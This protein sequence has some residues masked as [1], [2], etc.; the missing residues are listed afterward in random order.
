[1]K[2]TLIYDNTV[3]LSGLTPDWG[4]AC[5]VEAFGRTILFDTGAKGDLLFANMDV[6]G[7]SP[8][9]I[10]TVFISHNHL[11]HTGGLEAFMAIQ[12]AVTVIVPEGCQVNGSARDIV[13]VKKSLQLADGLF[14][15]GALDDFEQAL[16]IRERTRTAVV[17]GCSHPGV[18]RILDAAADFG[19][20]D[21]LI[22]GLHAFDDF[23]RLEPLDLVC[24]THCTQKIEEIKTRFPEKY[25]EGGAGRVIIL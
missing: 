11:D 19:T 7:I 1:M 13:T 3:C 8:G 10:D 18:G 23:Q 25:R 20:V 2:I 4:F 24:P 6:L 22:G 17:V 14:S 15:T 21:T 5:L 12:P 9:S 16:V